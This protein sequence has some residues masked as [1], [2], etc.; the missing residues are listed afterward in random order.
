MAH[1]ALT[2]VTSCRSERMELDL[3]NM[4]GEVVMP[5]TKSPPTEQRHLV[6]QVRDV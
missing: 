3:S 5:E 6:V 4:G 1:Y 2:V